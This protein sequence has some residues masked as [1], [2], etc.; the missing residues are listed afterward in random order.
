VTVIRFRPDFPSLLANAQISVSQAGY[1]TVCDLFRT[2]CRPVLIPFATG[3]ET[4]QTVRAEKL[5]ALGLAQVVDEASLT[6]EA[7]AEA[8]RRA[9]GITGVQELPF[10]L[11]G[12]ERSA[13]IVAGMLDGRG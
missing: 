8:I 7:L 6:G 10:S 2:T 12:A 1:N 3:G 11:D 5:K 13:E 9:S 4:E